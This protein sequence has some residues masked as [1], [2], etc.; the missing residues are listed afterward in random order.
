VRE[1]MLVSENTTA[2][3]KD[4]RDLRALEKLIAALGEIEGLDWVRLSYL[5][6][7]E[8]RD[9]LI[10]AMAS[11]PNVV[12]YADLSFQHAA[13]AVLKAMKRY[14]SPEVFLG[15]LDRVRAAMPDV[16]AR[17]NVIVGFPGETEPDIEILKQ[18]LVDARLDAVGVFGYSNE[19]GTAAYEYRGQ[20]DEAEIA[21]RVA[22]VSALVDV[23][24]EEVAADRVGRGVRVL[25]E[26]VESGVTGRAA[27]QGPEVDGTVVLTD[28]TGEH[29]IGDFV[30]G[31]V[32]GAEGVD[33][34]VEG[35]H[36]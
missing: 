11:T 8:M 34:I 9:T 28:P 3:G 1:V 13:P 26:Q 30:D 6:P 7:A 18:F 24:N 25:I 10:A 5:Q 31:L 29:R 2:Y 36:V 23:L 14:G 35:N 32:V 15:L 27:H 17:S 4:V 21:A 22:E 20:L 16:G 19:E 33:L 12:P